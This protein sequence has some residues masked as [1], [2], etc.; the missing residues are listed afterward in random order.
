MHKLKT[1]NVHCTEKALLI[2][3]VPFLSW[4]AKII[5]GVWEEA[6]KTEVK[7]NTIILARE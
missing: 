1:K 7:K 4:L 6:I 2:L 3:P 5:K